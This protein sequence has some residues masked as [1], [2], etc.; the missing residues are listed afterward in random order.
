MRSKHSNLKDFLF[1]IKTIWDHGKVYTISTLAV[2]LFITPINSVASVLFT[3][4]VINAT[5]QK[6]NFR[7]ILLIVLTFLTILLFSN[8]FQSV[9]TN[10][11]KIPKWTEIS[12]KINYSIYSQIKHTDFEYFDNPDFYN[13]FTWAINEYSNKSNEANALLQSICSSISTI[14]SMTAIITT[15]GPGLILITI[16]EMIITIAIEM[17]RNRIGMER[18]E[19]IIP[20]DR[21]IGYVQKIYF[22]R[23]YAADVRSTRLTDFLDELYNDS[24]KNKNSIVKHYAIKLLKW[25][26]AQNIIS[27]LYITPRKYDSGGFDRG[28]AYLKKMG[29]FFLKINDSLFFKQ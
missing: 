19:K 12:Q 1:L 25:I 15:L 16:F 10:A 4:T 20:L 9:F 11:Y 22:H 23:E 14:I 8:L 28:K 17:K 2:S 27:V 29:F 26:N 7:E 21:K 5:S 18:Q 6:K 24:C 3:Q 13:N